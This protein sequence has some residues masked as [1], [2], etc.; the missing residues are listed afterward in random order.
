MELYLTEKA[1]LGYRVGELV[2]MVLLGAIGVLVAASAVTVE[3][4]FTLPDL[5]ARAIIFS[6]GALCIWKGALGPFR[7]QCDSK[8]AHRMAECFFSSQQPDISIERLSRAIGEKDTERKIRCLLQKKYLKNVSLDV[9]NQRV[10]LSVVNEATQK[11][12]YET[13]ICPYCGGENI[14]RPGWAAACQYCGSS[15]IQ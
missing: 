8:L 3:L 12:Q 15:L 11:E 6:L 1:R 7:R 2:R 10:M 5:A 9:I 14:V 4:E 13:I